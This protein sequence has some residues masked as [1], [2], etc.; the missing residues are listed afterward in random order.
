M[1]GKTYVLIHGGFHGG[2]CWQPVARRLS[3]LGHEVYTPTHTGMGERSHLMA[4]KPD[5]KLF[6]EDLIQLFHYEDIHDAIVVGHSF[7]GSSVS[8]LADRVP[9][10]V[11]HLVYLDAML[12]RSGQCPGDVAPPGRI[13]R[14]KEMAIDTPHG[15][16]MMPADPTAFGIE[17]PELVEWVRA[18]LSPQPLQTFLDRIHLDNPLGNGKPATYIACTSP[19]WDGTASS[20]ELARTLPGWEWLEIPCAHDAMLLMPEQLTSMLDPLG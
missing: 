14:Y 5:M 12:L 1:A 11:R 6:A 2:W 3:A 10:H 13:E 19:W 20:R 7:G 4:M 8:I 9:E 18:R 17:D 15:K 16:I